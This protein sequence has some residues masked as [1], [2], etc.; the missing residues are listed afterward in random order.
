V[1]PELDGTDNDHRIAHELAELLSDGSFWSAIDSSNGGGEGSE[2]L[3]GR[4]LRLYGFTSP[5]AAERVRDWATPR[6]FAV[7]A[8]RDAAD[9]CAILTRPWPSADRVGTGP[10]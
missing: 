2:E 1:N 4:A 8:L 7:G 5:L 10:G 3:V 9:A 6:D